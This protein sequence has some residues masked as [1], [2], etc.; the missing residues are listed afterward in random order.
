MGHPLAGKE[1]R[2][3]VP[4]SVVAVGFVQ[5]GS[6]FTAFNRRPSSTSVRWAA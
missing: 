2:D 4:G 5:E 3:Q 6:V 1:L